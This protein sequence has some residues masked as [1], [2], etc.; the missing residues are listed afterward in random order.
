MFFE[1]AIKAIQEDTDLILA[2]N[3]LDIEAGKRK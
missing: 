2:A 3:Q 1:F